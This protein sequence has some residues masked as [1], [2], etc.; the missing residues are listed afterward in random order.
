VTLSTALRLGRVSNLP[1]VITNVVAAIALA[2]ARAST[3]MITAV[4]IAM[5]LMYL[6]GAFLNDAFDRDHDRI[7]DATRPI[8]SGAVAA[9]FVF[10]AGFAMLGGGILLVVA[11]ALVTGG[12]GMPILAVIALGSLI[13]FYDADHRDNPLA[14][15]VMGVCRGLVYAVAALLVGPVL[16]DRVL[17]AGIIVV[18]YST[19]LAYVTRAKTAALWPFALLAVPLVAAWPHDRLGLA[20]YAAFIMWVGR[21]LFVAQG[22][23]DKLAALVAGSSLLDALLVANR[24]KPILAIF[25]LVVFTLATM[26]QRIEE[27]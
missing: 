26:L 13:V 7:S 1:T 6:A 21:A 24:G 25:I 23:K 17:F 8:P 10:D 9:G 11:L 18:A 15:L 14:P 3:P 27:G 22:R 16:G 2:G 19:G 5:S 12:G 20:V 4:C